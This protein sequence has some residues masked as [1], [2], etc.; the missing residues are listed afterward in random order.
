[1][2]SE[3][4]LNWPEKELSITRD[5]RALLDE[6]IEKIRR[7]D[8]PGSWKAVDLRITELRDRLDRHDAETPCT[9][10]RANRPTAALRVFELQ[11]FAVRW[12]LCDR[13]WKL[14]DIGFSASHGGSGDLA[15]YLARPSAM[16][17]VAVRTYITAGRSLV[18]RQSAG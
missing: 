14:L 6:C 10:C 1:M 18:G 17:D 11:R 5:I 16:P 4:F 2:D 9:Y 13:C 8:P 12:H 3:K 7:Q 15:T